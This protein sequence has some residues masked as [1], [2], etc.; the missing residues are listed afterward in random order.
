[1]YCSRLH[2]DQPVLSI[3]I[4]FWSPSLHRLC[5]Y[6]T[7]RSIFADLQTADYSERQY[8]PVVVDLWCIVPYCIDC[9]KLVVSSRIPQGER[10]ARL[11]GRIEEVETHH[12]CLPWSKNDSAGYL[13]PTPPEKVSTWQRGVEYFHHW[14][15]LRGFLNRSPGA[16]TRK[17]Q[18]MSPRTLKYD[19]LLFESKDIYIYCK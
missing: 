13:Y 19:W 17:V 12:P 1:M 7:H 14:I 6:R 2:L 4:W 15:V 9:T 16:G 18:S 3:T 10:P 11:S 8:V 5:P